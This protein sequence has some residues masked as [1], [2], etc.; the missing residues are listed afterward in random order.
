[1]L[2]WPSS[3]RR[4]SSLRSDPPESGAVDIRNPIVLCQAFVEERVVCIQQVHKRVVFRN[5][6]FEEK[7]RLLL[8]RRPQ[9]FV[10]IGKLGWIRRQ[11]RHVAQ[12]EPL[13][14]EVADQRLRARIAGACAGPAAPE[15]R[16]LSVSRSSARLRSWSSGI[17]LHR[18][19]DKRDASSRSLIRN[20]APAGRFG[21]SCST[22]NRN[23][24]PPRILWTARPIPTSNPPS[25]RPSL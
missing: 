16:D 9:V 2:P 11:H 14:E 15:L 22:R 10:P 25:P 24:G 17:V 7:L 20:A 5:H 21:G 19:N 23:S 3:P 18:K 8:K 13:S 1:M 12:L 4:F 6:A